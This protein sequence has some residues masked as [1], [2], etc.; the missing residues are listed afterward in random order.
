LSKITVNLLKNIFNYSEK[1]IVKIGIARGNFLE[2][3]S[4]I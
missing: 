4:L 2:E 3:M 1:C